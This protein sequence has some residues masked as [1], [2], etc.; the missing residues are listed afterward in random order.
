MKPKRVKNIFRILSRNCVG[1]TLIEMLITALIFSIVIG[2]AT[3]VFVSAIRMQKYNLTY[4]QLLNQTSYAME[5]MG[6]AV[7]M[8]KRND[9]TLICSNIDPN[10]NYDYSGGDRIEF[11]TYHNPTQCWKFFRDVETD[12]RGQFGKLKIE[13]GEISY[14][15]TSDGFDVISFNVVIPGNDPNDNLQPRATIFMEIH[16]RGSGFQPEIKIQTTISQRNLDVSP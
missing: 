8:A 4:Q 15:L 9:E 6:R 5:Y 2:I 13:K 10:E 14:D 16:G 11:D 7:R 3:G 1:F 12:S